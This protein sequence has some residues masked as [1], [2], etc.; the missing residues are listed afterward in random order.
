M[1]A[2]THPDSARVPAH[3]PAPRVKM[4]MENLML[5]QNLM[6]WLSLCLAGILAT[7]GCTGESDGESTGGLELDLELAGGAEIDEVL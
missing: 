2:S 4:A 5:K 6:A 3:A 7:T 1:L